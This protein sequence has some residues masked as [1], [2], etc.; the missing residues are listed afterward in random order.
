MD[1]TK[2]DVARIKEIAYKGKADMCWFA[3]NRKE[4]KGLIKLAEQY[5]M[6]IE[7]KDDV[8]KHA[9][10]RLETIQHFSNG[11]WDSS[12]TQTRIKASLKYKGEKHGPDKAVS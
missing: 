9:L 5:F 11:Q 4:A 3:P 10:N 2:E 8:L 6:A 7:S 1:L 12:V